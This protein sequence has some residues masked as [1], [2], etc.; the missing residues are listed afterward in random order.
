MAN[1]LFLSSEMVPFCKTGG[2]ADVSGALP[3]AFKSRGHDVKT[4]VPFYHMINQEMQVHSNFHIHI[5]G[6]PKDGTFLTNQDD[7][8]NRY[9][10]YN[11]GY[12]DREG[13]YGDR[14]GDYGDNDER[15]AF[16]CEAALLLCKL[17]NWVP[18]IIQ[19]ND[20]QCGILAPILRLKYRNDPFFAKTK[21]VFTIHNLA[22]QGFFDSNVYR[23][24]DLPDEVMRFDGMEYH[25]AASFLKAGL[26]YSDFITTVSPTYAL[27]IQGSEYGCGMEKVLQSRSDRLAGILNGIDEQEWNP[28]I[29]PHLGGYNY[30]MHSLGVK[31]QLKA[32]FLNSIG[33]KYWPE[34]PLIG[35]VSR[36]AAQKGIS[37]IESVTEQVLNMGTQ[38]VFLGSGDQ[39][40]I[41]SLNYFQSKYPSQV[42]VFDTFSTAL[43]HQIEAAS[44]YFIMPSRYEPCGL[45]QMY[46]LR[47][48]TL[49]IVFHTGGLADTV[50]DCDS[51]PE[52][53][54]GYSFYEYSKSGFLGAIERALGL[55]RFPDIK[56]IVQRRGMSTDFSWTRSAQDYENLF[57]FLMSEGN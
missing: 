24:F 19:I 32:H 47:Y 4:V 5:S 11:P 41:N 29:D 10:V 50:F 22:F 51:N 55:Y 27:E 44:D 53:G 21:L 30:D 36:F 34:V 23:K 15:Y 31:N 45:N 54:N 18:D 14:Y 35:M 12:Y 1:V 42:R 46:S 6:Y 8:V 48:G 20:W 3:A 57:Q 28:A 52:I 37:L 38:M 26:Q 17:E 49:P 16:F 39:G 7:G 2:L 40:F 9:F 43:S 33:L 13:I 25:G 56:E